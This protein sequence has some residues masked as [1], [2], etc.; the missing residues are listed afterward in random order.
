MWQWIAQFLGLSGRRD[1]GSRGEKHAADWLE[2][3]RGYSVVTRNWRSP[4]DRRDEIDLVCRDGEVLVFVEVKARAAGALVPGYYAVDQRKK[5]V[6]R[7]AIDAYLRQLA[8]APRTFRFDVVEV[9]HRADGAAPEVLHFENI[10]L[11]PKH[12]RP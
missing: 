6:M 2:R 7:R 3:E 1:A 4:R 10:P 5:R 11:F 12:Y 9:A 8:P